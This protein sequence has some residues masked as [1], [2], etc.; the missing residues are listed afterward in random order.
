MQ[1][2]VVFCGSSAGVRPIYGEVAE[3]LGTAIARRGLGTVYGGASIGLMGRLADAAL[4]ADGEVIGVIPAS[5]LAREIAHRS[6]S[7]LEV[8]DTMHQR[9]ARMVE[10]ADLGAIVLPGGF[11][12]LDE[13]FELLTWMQLGIVDRGLVVLDV[14]G[15]WSS[16]CAF[17]DHAEREG[18]VKPPHRASV[19]VVDGVEAALDA[20]AE[21]RPAAASKW[22]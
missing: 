14:D 17:L 4:A 10:L 5:I 18:F 21:R 19:R 16:L 9:K 13:S 3:Q 2:V 12:T 22:G 15:Y 7:R 20:L 8:V 6:L 1:R 11:G